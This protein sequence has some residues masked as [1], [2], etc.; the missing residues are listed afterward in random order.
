MTGKENELVEARGKT[1]LEK[2]WMQRVSGKLL[3]GAYWDILTI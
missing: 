1:S 3:K 2:K